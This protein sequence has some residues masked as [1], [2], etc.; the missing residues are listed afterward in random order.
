MLL[1]YVHCG[2]FCVDIK[3]NLFMQIKNCMYDNM[4]IEYSN[5]TITNLIEAYNTY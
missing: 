3:T 2:C 5:S 4:T 1:I